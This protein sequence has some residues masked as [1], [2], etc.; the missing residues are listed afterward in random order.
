MVS[1]TDPNRVRLTGENSFMRLGND[2]G[3]EAAT[4][5]S[6]WRV[7]LSPAGPGHALFLKSELTDGDPRIYAD[8]IALASWLREDIQRSMT[9]EY[10]DPDIPITEAAF[11]KSGDF[12]SFWTESVDS[13]TDVISL[14]W[15]DFGEPFMVR[16]S[17]GGKPGQPHGV[18]SCLVPARRARLTIN[19]VA[20]KGRPFP[21][22]Q[23]GATSSSCSLALS[24]T[25]VRPYET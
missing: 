16:T 18:Y 9:P 23:E 12:R 3:G 20:A 17:P 8:N 24:E 2:E 14:T 13:D 21:K 22:E 6:H 25:W 10:G 11:D 5:A 15:Y 7:L 4:H 19:G 1:S